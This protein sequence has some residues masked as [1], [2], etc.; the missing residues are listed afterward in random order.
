[1]IAGLWP[2]A[3]FPHNRVQWLQNENGIHFDGRGIAYGAGKD[4]GRFPR[5][6]NAKTLTVELWLKPET[7]PD[8]NLP[9]FLTIYDRF[10]LNALYFAQWRSTLIVRWQN[11]STP[12]VFRE[13]GVANALNA[14]VKRLITIAFD[15]SRTVVFVDGKLGGQHPSNLLSGLDTL[16]VSAH[17]ER[18]DRCIVN[19][20]IAP[21]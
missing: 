11:L 3:F 10:S 12:L 8:S 9:V 21:S 18:S 15:A 5:T 4:F 2:F 7:E 16:R 1:L 17:R 14:G 13:F 6:Q 19:T 20:R